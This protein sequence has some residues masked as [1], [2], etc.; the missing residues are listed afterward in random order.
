MGVGHLGGQVPGH[1]QGVAVAAADR[2]LVHAGAPFGSG[3]ERVGQSGLAGDHLLAADAVGQQGDGPGEG[4]LTHPVGAL[5]AHALEGGVGDI[6]V[7]FV[8]GERVRECHEI[9]GL[10]VE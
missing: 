9:A 5:L 7:E 6:D 10:R 4:L 3:D 2:A 8:G 1:R